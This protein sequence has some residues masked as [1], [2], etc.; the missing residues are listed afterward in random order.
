ML[1]TLILVFWAQETPK[2]SVLL[3]VG[4]ANVEKV[5]DGVQVAGVTTRGAQ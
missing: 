5:R 3:G 4:T 2:L 1:L